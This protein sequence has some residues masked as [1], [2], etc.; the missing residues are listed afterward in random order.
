[1]N[2]QTN[3]LFGSTQGAVTG[4][5]SCSSMGGGRRRKRRT[6]KKGSK[7]RY[8]GC[9]YCGCRAPKKKSKSSRKNKKRPK[10]KRGGTKLKYGKKSRK[11]RGRHCGRAELHTGGTSKQSVGMTPNFK[12]VDINS[13]ALANPTPVTKY[14]Q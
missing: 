4:C 12:S 7:K 14:I 11:I 9:L 13:T 5:G 1:M 3:H 6:K 8:G 10:N 2:L